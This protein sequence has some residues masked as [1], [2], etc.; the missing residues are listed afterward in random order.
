MV[1]LALN[2]GEPHPSGKGA[3]SAAGAC[4]LSPGSSLVASSLPHSI[5]I[6]QHQL[7]ITKRV[8]QMLKE[9][10]ARQQKNG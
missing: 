2:G 8:K 4:P 10:L 1:P 3:Q 5:F 6:E 7:H 9:K